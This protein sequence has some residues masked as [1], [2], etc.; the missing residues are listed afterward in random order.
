MELSR[1]V[2]PDFSPDPS[3]EKDVQM[4]CHWQ[5]GMRPDSA[6][7]AALRDGIPGARAEAMWSQGG[8]SYAN[9][10]TKMALAVVWPKMKAPRV[11]KRTP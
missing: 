6:G 11:T 8:H 7:P 2:G 3:L 1:G 4:S 9:R 10:S 5:R